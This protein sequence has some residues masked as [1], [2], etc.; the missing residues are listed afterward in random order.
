L[1]HW[2]RD[3]AWLRGRHL[4]TLGVR[5]LSVLGDV[6]HR[7]NALLNLNSFG[8]W[9]LDN[10]G[11]LTTT[12]HGD[13]L[14]Y[15]P[16]G[17]NL[18][19]DNL[20]AWYVDPPGFGFGGWDR[21]GSL[22]HFERWSLF[23]NRHAFFAGHFLGVWHLSVLGDGFCAVDHLLYGDGDRGGYLDH[24][25]NLASAGHGEA[26]LDLFGARY[27]FADSFDVRLVNALHNLFRGRHLF[28]N[29][30]A[31][32]VRNCLLYHDGLLAWHLAGVRLHFVTGD[33]L[34]HHLWLTWLAN[35]CTRL[36]HGF[37]T[38]LADGFGAWLTNLFFAGGCASDWLASL[39]GTRSGTAFTALGAADGTTR[40]HG[41]WFLV[42]VVVVWQK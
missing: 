35:W 31:L 26:L 34:C 40:R 27:G 24:L 7:V 11:D 23:L 29:G 10:L 41:S 3:W 17:L 21:L 15:F 16:G 37:S 33:R 30:F 39:R 36:A 19:L 1:A 5:D 14:L 13:H 2:R 9:H 18:L 22:F 12:W 28:L 20:G 8:S 6:H 42:S 4:D 25:C 38:W 32:D